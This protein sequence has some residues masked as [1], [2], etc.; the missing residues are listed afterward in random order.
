M[1]ST[2]PFIYPWKKWFSAKQKILTKGK[3][4]ACQPHSMAQQVRNAARKYGKT[5]SV[6]IEDETVTIEVKRAK[7]Q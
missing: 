6:F 1:S 4:F 3:D 7:I 5:V 2:K